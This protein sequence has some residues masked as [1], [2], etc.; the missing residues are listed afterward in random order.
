MIDAVLAA[1]TSSPLE[2]NQLRHYPI[3]VEQ[4]AAS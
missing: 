1:A 3:I 4:V 2:A